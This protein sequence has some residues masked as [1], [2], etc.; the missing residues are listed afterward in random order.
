MLIYLKRRPQKKQLDLRISEFNE[1]LS[2]VTKKS[3]KVFLLLGEPKGIEFDPTLSVRHN[4]K[5]YITIEQ[6]KNAYAT[7][8]D[9]LQG[10]TKPDNLVIIDPIEYL[11][12]DVCMVRDDNFKYYYKDAGHMRPWYA[13]KSLGYLA[14][15][16]Q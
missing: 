5:S 9:A 11:C 10:I 12:S 1:F 2:F 14:Q 6:A 3:K 13:K 4:L 7:H 16:F 8:Y 15:V